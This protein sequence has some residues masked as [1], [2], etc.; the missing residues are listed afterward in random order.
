[1]LIITQE[2]WCSNQQSKFWSALM[3]ASREI[4]DIQTTIGKSKDSLNR[5][6][7]TRVQSLCALCLQLAFISISSF[8]FSLSLRLVDVTQRLSIGSPLPAR[9]FS[10]MITIKSRALSA[11]SR[12]KDAAAELL[13]LTRAKRFEKDAFLRCC[14]YQ[15]LS[16]SLLSDSLFVAALQAAKDALQYAGQVTATATCVQLYKKLT[17]S[18]YP[19]LHD[20]DAPALRA[21]A[22]HNAAIAAYLSGNLQSSVQF[23]SES[24]SAG[25]KSSCVSRK[26]LACF[27][28]TCSAFSEEFE[29][30]S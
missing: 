30:S 16:A 13:A 7:N 12:P 4:D 20:V 3:K 2:L 8:E 29:G 14:V 1:M 19:T 24:V 28:A 6:F 18:V 11:L 25:R 5:Q 27:E 15:L 10:W 26:A 23:S 22:A 9:L 21:Y 17:S